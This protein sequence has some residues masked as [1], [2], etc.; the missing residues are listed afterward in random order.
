MSIP[1]AFDIRVTKTDLQ[2]GL[3]TVPLKKTTSFEVNDKTH[4]IDVHCLTGAY[5]TIFRLF[6]ENAQ[7]MNHCVKNFLENTEMHTPLLGIKIKE[8]KH[9]F[10]QNPYKKKDY[11]DDSQ[12]IIAFFF[13]RREELDSFVDC[14]VP[15]FPGFKTDRNDDKPSIHLRSKKFGKTSNQIINL[16]NVFKSITD[17]RFG[18]A[19]LNEAL[20]KWN[21]PILLGKRIQSEEK[22]ADK[23]ESREYGRH[24]EVKP[25]GITDHL[26]IGDTNISI[27]PPLKEIE[28]W[29]ANPEAHK[30]GG[31][32]R[33][34]NHLKNELE[35][36]NNQ[37]A[38]KTLLPQALSIPGFELRSF[39]YDQFTKDT[40]RFPNPLTTPAS[41]L[42][43][44]H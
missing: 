33:F 26:Q 7:M 18:D 6:M 5:K 30:S 39:M 15:L 40:N 9:M 28:D 1:T 23:D 13:N 43:I 31:K 3:L 8:V 32:E 12:L 14:Y 42:N 20:S 22:S 35:K 11:L 37:E 4:T 36:T 27:K 19:G 41:N 34:L 10:L 29:I 16:R 38:L 24:Y 17:S 2:L 21:D 25:E 44:E